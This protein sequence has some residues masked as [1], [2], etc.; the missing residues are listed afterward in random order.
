MKKI[1]SKALSIR[2]QHR[3]ESALK[4]DMRHNLRVGKQPLYIDESRTKLNSIILEPQSPSILRKLCHERRGGLMKRKA[5]SNMA[6]TTSFIITFGHDLQEQVSALSRSEQD[7]MYHKIAL[8]ITEHVEIELTGLVAHRDEVGQHCHGQTPA[9]QLGGK[10]MSKVLTPSVC[11][12]IQTVAMQAAQKFLPTIE[13]G[14]RKADRI[15]AGEHSSAIN[16]RTVK[17]LHDDLPVELEAAK[18]EL[19]AATE[20]VLVMSGRVERLENKRDL[21]AAEVKRLEIYRL[22]LD[23][24]IATEK[25]ALLT[26]TRLHRVDSAALDAREAALEARAEALHVAE[27]GFEVKETKLRKVEKFVNKLLIEFGADLGVGNKL[28]AIGDALRAYYGSDV[29]PSNLDDESPSAG[30]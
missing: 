4:N 28:T 22:R 15:V 2:F 1:P 27:K 17:Q 3:S 19:F 20:Q 6:V 26:Q 18:A 10:P 23:A 16:N 5:K 12:E 25:L 11:S 29:D 30:M 9:R 21:T 8:A 24:N 14:K 7:T 13:R